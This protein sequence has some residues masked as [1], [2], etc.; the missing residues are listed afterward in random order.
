MPMNGDDPV[1]LQAYKKAIP[2]LK[3]AVR[4][5][6]GDFYEIDFVALQEHWLAT[7]SAEERVA[8]EADCVAT[9]AA[10][11]E[12]VTPDVVQFLLSLGCWNPPTPDLH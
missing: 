11:L 4:A 12:K 3:R 6:G 5:A 2:E 7:L 10:D 8:L 1:V 9:A